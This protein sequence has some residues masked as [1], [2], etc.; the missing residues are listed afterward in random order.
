MVSNVRAI[1]CLSVATG[2]CEVP[3]A[4]IL[5]TCANKVGTRPKMC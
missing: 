3:V 1:T 2:S 4:E 5:V